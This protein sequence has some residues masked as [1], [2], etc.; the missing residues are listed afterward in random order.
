MGQA[1]RPSSH[2]PALPCSTLRYPAAL[3]CLSIRVQ[4]RGKKCIKAFE[5]VQRAMRRDQP[6]TPEP[7]RSMLPNTDQPR[8][9]HSE[10]HYTA[11]ILHHFTERR[12]RVL[13]PSASSSGRGAGTRRPTQCWRAPR[14]PLYPPL[15]CR[16]T[17]VNHSPVFYVLFCV[18][19]F[20]M[21]YDTFRVYYN[22]VVS[23]MEPLG[24]L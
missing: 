14:S 24:L 8:I 15:V 18:F 9:P 16:Y 12:P 20:L 2:Y 22:L 19:V 3:T 5:P 4:C 6:K 7:M 21:S 11:T 17:S 23:V 10:Y 13:V 1:G